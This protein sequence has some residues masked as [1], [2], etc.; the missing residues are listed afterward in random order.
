LSFQQEAS[1]HLELQNRSRE[2]DEGFDE[3]SSE[4][5]LQYLAGGDFVAFWQLWQR[6]EKYLYRVCLQNLGGVQEEAEDALSRLLIKLWDSLPRHAG[7][8][9]NLRAWLTR[10]AYNLC[11]DIH[12]ERKQT[13]HTKRLEDVIGRDDTS[14]LHSSESPEEDALRREI[15]HYLYQSVT[16]L[17]PEL[18]IPFLLHFLH[19]IPYGEIAAQLSITPENARKR[20]QMARQVLRDRLK[21]YLTGSTGDFGEDVGVD[22]YSLLD[23][24][25]A[26]ERNQPNAKDLRHQVA[27]R[28]V[29]VALNSGIE[30]SFYVPLDHKP[31]KLH[32]KIKSVSRYTSAHPHGWKKRLELAHLLYEAGE[33]TG[34]VEEYRRVL[35]K[36]PQLLDVYLDLGNVFD[37]MESQS[38]SID[39]YQKALQ[40]AHEPATRHRIIGLLETRRGNY[41]RAVEEFQKAT[42]IEPQ[43]AIHW[44]Q[45]GVLHAQEDYPLEALGCFQELLKLSPWDS[46]GLTHLPYLLRDLG[47]LTEADH[48]VDLVFARR[49]ENVLSLKYLADSRSISRQVFGKEGRSTL[50]LIREALRLAPGSPEI[51]ESLAT[52][53]FCRGEWREGIVLLEKF[54]R[55][56][57][58]CPEGWIYYAKALFQ[59]GV[60]GEAAVAVN[61]ALRLDHATWKTNLAALEILTWHNI[62]LRLQQQAS[63]IVKEFPRRWTAWAAAARALMIGLQD[64]DQACAI[65]AQ[66]PVLQPRL[67]NSWFEHSK[68]LTMAARYHEAIVAAE[69]GWKFLHEKEDGPQSISAAIGLAQNYILIEA[70]GAELRWIDEA[71]LR[72]PAFIRWNP[73]EGYFFQGK[74]MELT[75]EHPA[76]LASY[77]EALKQNLVYPLR[78]EA[79]NAVKRLESPI[80]RRLRPF[81]L[82]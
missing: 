26:E 75:G 81:P 45:L 28:P 57:P 60:V 41:P 20:S 22:L 34:A 71:A 19:D 15:H 63:E 17:A 36:Q 62:P 1:Q 11:I 48:Y 70:H 58:S 33:W 25:G 9:K 29:K 43:H 69:V 66:A 46:V 56:H 10:S 51:H 37:L 39:T 68:I 2:E 38:D 12:R 47:R 82:R 72:L 61:R 30:R 7:G 80:S 31:L 40:I 24:P 50:A 8:I 52:Y 55:Q 32:P 76:A 79:G 65:S 44:R 21:N 23:N 67:A 73:A 6:H 18:R 3:E 49:S 59:T 54:T 53:H 77:V 4:L 5:Q 13:L 74:L 42:Q 16:K 35:E 27:L 78:L 64:V 14:L